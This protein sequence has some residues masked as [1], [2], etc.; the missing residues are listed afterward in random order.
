MKPN[1][2]INGFRLWP[3][4]LAGQFIFVL[5]AALLLSQII[6]SVILL[7][8]KENALQGL[9]RR[10]TV[11]QIHAT[12]RL[13]QES[14]VSLHTSILRAASSNTIRFWLTPL[15]ISTRIN[16]DIETIFFT[17][18]FNN[19]GIEN[20][21][22]LGPNLPR[23]VLQQ[24]NKHHMKNKRINS[25]PS[26]GWNY[27]TLQLA[28]NQWLNVATRFN[29]NAPLFKSGNFISIVTT[30][31]I[32]IIFVIFMV[33]RITKPLHDLTRAADQLGCGEEVEPLQISGPYDLQTAMIAFN[34]MNERLN[35]FV[36]DR[37]N[38]LAAV[39][40]DLRTPITSLK[41]RAELL[42]EGPTQT[43]FLA[44]L[45]EMQ[46][47][48]DSTLS[49]IRDDANNEQTQSVDLTALLDSICEDFRSQGKKA[50]LVD[51]DKIFYSCRVVTL[52][53]ALNNVIENAIK[54]GKGAEVSIQQTTE[55]L[56][57]QIDDEGEGIP[58]SKIEEMFA[59]FSRLE[60]SR[61]Q[62]TG[63]VG[64]GLSIAR[65]VIR[66]HGG[67]IRLT[68]RQPSGLCVVLTLPFQKIA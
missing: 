47:I 22:I 39:S 18:A 50:N 11:N 30:A 60:K 37:T 57:I 4:N 64:L 38:M 36:T 43:A 14:P 53:R 5:L 7:Q 20:V 29:P 45:D 59:P 23:N 10:G 54:Y 19:I 62:M 8:D 61:N 2:K 6:T 33:R 41:L 35:R 13:L 32:L 63:G 12:V 17:T 55:H 31:I 48:A 28:D 44:T 40:H 46:A 67:D 66:S 9:N 1:F 27:M 21:M 42:D 51:H 24:T 16:N 56:C 3:K 68:N 65:S 26:K 58:E 34:N 52:K 15:P 25:T 49:F